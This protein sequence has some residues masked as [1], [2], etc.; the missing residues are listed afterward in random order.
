MHDP[1]ADGGL[2][3]WLLFIDA[4]LEW[5]GCGCGGGNLVRLGSGEMLL[6]GWGLVVGRVGGFD[7]TC[8]RNVRLGVTLGKTKSWPTKMHGGCVCIRDQVV[9]ARGRGEGGSGVG[10]RG[11]Q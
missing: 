10:M 11:H 4:R 1:G 5:L 2:P 3:A 8:D 6:W 7:G 9:H